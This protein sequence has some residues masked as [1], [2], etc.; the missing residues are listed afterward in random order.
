MDRKVA[1][2]VRVFASLT[3]AEQEEAVAE[4]NK[5]IRGDVEVKKG[6]VGEALA[7]N[8]VSKMDLGPVLSA[9]PYCGK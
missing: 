1:G 4:L 2:T 6:V 7:Q 3:E 5:F 9:C 8:H